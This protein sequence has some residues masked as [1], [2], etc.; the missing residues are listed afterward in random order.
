[1][2]AGVEAGGVVVAFRV[3]MLLRKV[4]DTLRIMCLLWRMVVVEPL[5]EAAVAGV[6]TPV[7]IVGAVEVISLRPRGADMLLAVPFKTMDDVVML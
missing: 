2:P 4:L 6:V 7:L 3:A 1:M 5:M